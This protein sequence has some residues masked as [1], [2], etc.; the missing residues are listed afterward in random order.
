MSDF[1][2]TSKVVSWCGLSIVED[3]QHPIIFPNKDVYLQCYFR[4]KTG[5]AETKDLSPMLPA[6]DRPTSTQCLRQIYPLSPLQRASL[7]G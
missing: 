6:K 3:L 2:Q 1:S 5:K 4:A 7:P